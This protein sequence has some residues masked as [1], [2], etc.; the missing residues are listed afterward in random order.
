MIF[1][2]PA[3][4]GII[5]DGNRR[6]AKKMNISIKEAY[7]LGV[8]KI[9]DVL[10]WSKESGVKMVT[11]WGFS[12]ENFYRNA[13]EKKFLFRLF[14]GKIYEML[15]SRK[16]DKEQL[17]INVVGDRSDF[18]ESLIRSIEEMEESTRRYKK[19]QLNLALGYGGR[20]EI[21]NACNRLLAAGVRKVKMNDFN[22]YLFTTGIPDPDLI[23]RTSG[24]QRTSGFL[25]WQSV[26]SELI[27]LKPLWPEIQKQD[28]MTAIGEFESRQRRFGR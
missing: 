4:I 11:A 7:T 18:P 13:I 2:V 19:F 9:I 20:Q 21:V 16:F 17:R 23:I 10:D 5:P 26:Y 25:P 3:H 22:K 14:E 12:T 15:R 24:E 6:Y 1:L 28:F 27:F 8:Q